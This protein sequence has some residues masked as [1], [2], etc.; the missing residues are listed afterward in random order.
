MFIYFLSQIKKLLPFNIS[1]EN[2]FYNTYNLPYNYQEAL[3]FD[4]LTPTP[5]NYRSFWKFTLLRCDDIK[6][7]IHQKSNI[8]MSDKGELIGRYIDD[9]FIP[10]EKL[11][12]KDTITKWFKYCQ[13]S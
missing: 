13:Q 2:F 11:S 4:F 3:L 6:L 7:F 8:I 1:I 9:D 12:N 10:L 5:M